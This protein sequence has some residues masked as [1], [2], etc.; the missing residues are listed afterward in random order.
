MPR[1]VRRGLGLVDFKDASPGGL[2]KTPDGAS[3]G[4]ARA[5]DRG[6]TCLGSDGLSPLDVQ[7][8][9]RPRV[10]RRLIFRELGNRIIG[11][12]GSVARKHGGA[13]WRRV[14]FRHTLWGLI[15]DSTPAALLLVA[16]VAISSL[17]FL[18]ALLR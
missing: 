9:A 7:G 15:P 13:R 6:I 14:G 3:V 12:G 1:T 5:V 11:L 16:A 8:L 10:C 4:Y 2:W 17:V 18:Y